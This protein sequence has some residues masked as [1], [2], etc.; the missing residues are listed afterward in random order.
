M[1][2][3]PTQLHEGPPPFSTWDW[4]V[5]ALLVAAFLLFG[6]LAGLWERRH[7]EGTTA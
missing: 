6:L 4:V 5:V 7:S 1:V 2:P 3:L